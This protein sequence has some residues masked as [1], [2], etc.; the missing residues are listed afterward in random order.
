MSGLVAALELEQAGHTVT[1]I[2]GQTRPGGRV[3]TMRDGSGSPIAEAGAGR[4]PET[5]LWTMHYIE[6]M[7]LRTEPLH[8]DALRSVLF[9]Q[10][11][12]V[13]VGQG[14]D[15]ARYFDLVA[16]EKAAG[17]E[18]LA[19]A[20]ILSGV[21]LVRAS[22]T[23][24]GPDW[25]PAD[26]ASLDRLTVADYLRG[27]GVS[28]AAIELLTLGAFPHTISALTLFRVLA[29]YDRKRL[30]KIRGGNDLLPR[31][32]AARLK[33]P[34]AHGCLV[35]AIR[36]D[37][38]QVEVSVKTSTG[39]QQ[40]SAD[41]V[42][43]TIPFSLLHDV[44]IAPASSPEKQ[45]ILAAMR[46]TK[47]V[48]VAFKTRARPWERGGLSGF[49]Q[50]DSMAEVW[51]P[52]S[53]DLGEGGVLQFYQQGDRAAAMDEMS[54]GER[55]AF[56]SGAIERIFPD[57][58]ADVEDAFEHSWQRDPWA[59]GAYGI[60]APGQTYAWKNDLA[61]PEG[62][63]HFAGEHTSLEYAAWIEGAVRSGYRAAADVSNPRA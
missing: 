32:L 19:R 48:K 18:G 25:P 7:G 54:A 46:Y 60:A 39:R 27:R 6:Q 43:C 36:Q 2:E 49:A 11:K 1:V 53:D 34:I 47:A 20:H 10:G 42:I 35:Q 12:R 3:L 52:R 22:G 8:P 61:R 28:A 21:E 14:E 58:L 31:A 15:P 55:L 9:A 24:D 23:M 56:A 30:R 26:L 40:I 41:S 44:E 45:A 37:A 59:R 57:G 29:T 5:H 63:I 33:T 17:L 16:S 50:L 51:S 13:A 62:R 38:Q 4:I